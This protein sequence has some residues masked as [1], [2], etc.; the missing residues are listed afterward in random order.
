MIR[1]NIEKLFKEWIIMLYLTII[2]VTI[3][4]VEIVEN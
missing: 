1:S 4:N 2:T 3:Y